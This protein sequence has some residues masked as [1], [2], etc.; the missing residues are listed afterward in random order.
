MIIESHAPYIGQHCETTTNGNLLRQLDINLSEPMLFGLGEGL[1]FIYWKMKFMDFPFIGGRVKPMV[2]TDNLARNLN[3]D[4]EIRQTSSLKK[5][6]S[7]VVS[8]IADGKVVGLQLDCYHL[9]YF[10]NKIHFAGHFAAMVG[11]DDSDAFLVDTAQ[12]GGAVTTSLQSLAQARSEKGSMSARNLMY[13]LHRKQRDF[14]LSAAIRSAIVNNATDYLN[15]PIKN[16][17][18]KGIEKSAVEI[19]DW[20]HSSENVERD[21]STTAVLMEKAGTGG[22][23]FRNMYRD[24]L[25]QSNE[26]LDCAVLARAHAEFEQI[27]PLWTEVASLF[28]SAAKTSDI[29]HIN[30]ASSILTDL[31]AREYSAMRLL[32]ELP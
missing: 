4:I 1:S 10:T 20:F 21:F 26:V 6:W 8:N 32:R 16:F 27:A 17:C 30:E 15:P 25:Q 22:A 7:N 29:S 3:L 11:Y 12:Q 24:F 28:D 13:L 2:L 31:S 5:A 14:D 9:E 19:K 23:L 18:Y